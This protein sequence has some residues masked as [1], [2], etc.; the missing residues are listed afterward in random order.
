MYDT[1]SLAIDE[2]NINHNT[3]VLPDDVLIHRLAMLPIRET[4]SSSTH[5]C[6]FMVSNVGSHAITVMSHHMRSETCEVVCG[7]IPIVQ[8]VPGQTLHVECVIIYGKGSDHAKFIPVVAC[9]H[10]KKGS[11][12]EVFFDST[13]TLSF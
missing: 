1:S 7:N 5:K 10:R 13:G 3:S 9:A 6:V 4:S 2:C 8:L 12:Y 11:K